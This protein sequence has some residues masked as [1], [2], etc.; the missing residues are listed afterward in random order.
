MT[1]TTPRPIT[2]ALDARFKPT[3]YA[4]VGKENSFTLESY[5]ADGGYEAVQ[6]AFALGPDPVIDEM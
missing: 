5:R 2:S 4:R 1:M 6:R 3:L